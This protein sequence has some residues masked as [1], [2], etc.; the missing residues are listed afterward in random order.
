MLD[1]GILTNSSKTLMKS[2]MIKTLGDL[3]ETS[4]RRWQEAVFALVTGHQVEEID[5]SVEEN[6]AG[7]YTWTKSFDNLIGELVEDGYVRAEMR[8]GNRMIIQLEPDVVGEYSQ[9]GHGE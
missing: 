6:L 4:P 5:W 9:R 1:E 3:G 2:A 8:G 7:Y